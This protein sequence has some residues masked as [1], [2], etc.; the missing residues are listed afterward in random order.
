MADDRLYELV[1]DRRDGA[2]AMTIRGRVEI[3]SAQQL[4]N[5]ITAHLS[6]H[7]RSVELDL[8]GVDYFDSGGGALLIG[9]RQQLAFSGSELRIVGSTPAIDGFLNLVDQE[10]LLQPVPPPTAR[11]TSLIVKIGGETLKVLA[12]SREL[13]VFTGELILGLRD[14]LLQPRDRKSVV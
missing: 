5:E 4:L 8:S 7:P 13:M 11:R 6:D 12:D 14:A 10:A 1:A 3:G 9:L 2:L